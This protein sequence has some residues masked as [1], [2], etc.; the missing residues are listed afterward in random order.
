MTPAEWLALPPKRYIKF[1]PALA[2]VGGGALHGLALS[3][4]VYKQ[5][6]AG[7][8]RPWPLPLRMWQDLTG[9]SRNQL[10]RVLNDLDAA[11]LL[12][13][14]LKG[15]PRRGHYLCHL[16]RVLLGLA[17]FPN[18]IHS[19]HSGGSASD[20]NGGQTS[21]PPVAQASD[22]NGGS[23]SD[24][25]VARA[26]DN[27]DKSVR[28]LKGSSEDVPFGADAPLISSREEERQRKASLEVLGQ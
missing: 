23:A 13:C 3:Q 17:Q 4:A 18:D 1:I 10:A 22:R 7:I 8:G 24:P 16:D 14:E 5:R 25:P 6:H 11:G 27:Y 12:T 9:M 26:L 21:D 19:V 20:R 15:I 28:L 2:R